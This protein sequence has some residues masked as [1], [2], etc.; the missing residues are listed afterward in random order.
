MTAAAF[1]FN[2]TGDPAYDDAV[3][4]L[5]LATSDTADVIPKGRDQ[6]WAT[7]ACLLSPRPSKHPALRD[8]MRKSILF[9]A[10]ERETSLAAGRPSR[11]SCDEESGYFPTSQDVERTLLAHRVCD[12]PAEKRRLLDAL[13]TEADW[14]LGRNPLNMVQMT[15]ATTPLAGLRS[16]ENAYTSGRN[17][18]TPGLHP[19]HTPYF[20]M[21][22][23]GGAKGMIMARPR[24]MAAHGYPA[25]EQWP[26]A[27]CAF[28][29]RWVWAHSEFTP[30]QTMRGKTALYGYLYG[31]SKR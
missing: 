9:T 18:G 15:T 29:T 25:F 7:A 28:N 14:G 3:N 24:W 8:R 26:H 12:D 13:V 16:V 17:D 5:S 1:L 10:V 20:N 2:L 27:E 11:R 30:Q 23:W 6:I 21:D 22:D 19:G 4:A 31:I